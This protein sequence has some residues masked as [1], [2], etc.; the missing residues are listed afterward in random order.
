MNRRMFAIGAAL[1]VV[2]FVVVL[3]VLLYRAQKPE[4]PDATA[5]ADKLLHYD[6]AG[7]N[8]REIALWIYGNYNCHTCHTL[9]QTGAFGLTALGQEL[10]KGFE[11]CPGM[12]LT[13]MQSLSVPEAQWTDKHKRVRVNFAKFGCSFCHQMNAAGVGLTAVGSRAANLHMSCPQLM[14]TVNR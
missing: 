11:G 10:A 8:P 7:K 12:L 9:T 6:A 13:V 1:F 2:S 3:S 5:I 4:P 14:S